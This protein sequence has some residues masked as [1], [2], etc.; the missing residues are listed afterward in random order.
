MLERSILAARRR[1]RSP[2]IR[3]VFAATSVHQTDDTPS[4]PI[5]DYGGGVTSLVQRERTVKCC[6]SM[7][8]F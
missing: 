6:A 5:N 4:V 3:L 8:V 2:T 7:W 1:Q